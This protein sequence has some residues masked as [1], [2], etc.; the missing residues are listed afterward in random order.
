[1]VTAAV[2]HLI[3]AIDSLIADESAIS[4]L[5]NEAWS[6]HE[7]TD[8]AIDEVRFV[9]IAFIFVSSLI[10]LVCYLLKVFAW[11]EK[12]SKPAHS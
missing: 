8:F 12:Y 5:L 6:S 3:P 10:L 1:V 4:E 2:P 9:N 7:I 11:F